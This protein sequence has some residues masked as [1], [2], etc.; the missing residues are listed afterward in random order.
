MLKSEFLKRAEDT[1]K[2]FICKKEFIKGDDIMEIFDKAFGASVK[3][4]KR[5]SFFTEDKDN[6]VL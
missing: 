3:I 1:S 6:A 4:H 2:C 5:H